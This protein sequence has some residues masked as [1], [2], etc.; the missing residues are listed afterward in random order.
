MRHF[1]HQGRALDWAVHA[2]VRVVSRGYHML[3]A[4]CAGHAAS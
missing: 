1:R 2:A 4:A 3:R